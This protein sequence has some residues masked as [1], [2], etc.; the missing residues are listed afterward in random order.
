M[1]GATATPFLQWA[2]SC[3]IGARADGFGMLVEQA[4]EAFALWRGVRPSTEGVRRSLKPVAPT[5]IDNTP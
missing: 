3:G 5:P 4:A 2:E 1:Y